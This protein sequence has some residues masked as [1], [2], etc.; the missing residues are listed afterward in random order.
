[1]ACNTVL[2]VSAP[3]KFWAETALPEVFH[4]TILERPAR[5]VGSKGLVLGERESLRL[6]FRGREIKKNYI[7]SLESE[8]SVCHLTKTISQANS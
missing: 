5:P 7:E 6:E 3:P 1:M 4:S 8:A 2:T